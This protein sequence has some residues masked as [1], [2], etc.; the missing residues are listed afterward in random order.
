[1]PAP[2]PETL[3][4]AALRH[5]DTAKWPRKIHRAIKAAGSLTVAAEALGM[6]YRTLLELTRTVP[7][8]TEGIELRGPGRPRVEG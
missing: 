7:A 4:L 5:S 2:S 3:A 8:L 1:M 6:S